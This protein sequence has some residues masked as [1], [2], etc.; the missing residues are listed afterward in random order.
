MFVKRYTIN[1]Q[2][3][4]TLVN[5]LGPT[6]VEIPSSSTTINIP[7]SLDFQIVDQAE[8]LSLIHI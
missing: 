7:I 2:N 8:I 1:I 6:S 3:Q 5:E 4:K